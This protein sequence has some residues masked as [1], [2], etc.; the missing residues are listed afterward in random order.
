MN[1]RLPTRFEMLRGILG[2]AIQLP[3]VSITRPDI[4]LYAVFVYLL[5]I[6]ILYAFGFPI[7]WWLGIK[8][9]VI[10]Y[11]VAVLGTAAVSFV[12]SAPY[13]GIRRS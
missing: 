2:R 13:F 1:D 9:L 12:V 8:L 4:L 10:E 7:T 5:A 11:G 6:G 3:L